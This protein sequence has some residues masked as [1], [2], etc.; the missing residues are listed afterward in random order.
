M[1]FSKGEI[2]LK[3]FFIVLISVLASLYLNKKLDIFDFQN[4]GN[5]QAF[6]IIVETAWIIIV[7]FLLVFVHI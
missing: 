6:K 4:L 3:D 7:I 5:E 2:I 1:T